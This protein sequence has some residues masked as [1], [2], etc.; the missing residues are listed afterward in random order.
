MCSFFSNDIPIVVVSFV[1][2]LLI[3]FKIYATN[4]NILF[5]ATFINMLPAFL[6]GKKMI[7][8]TQTNNNH[9]NAR[10]YLWY[11][12]KTI[13]QCV[14][15][16]TIFSWKKWT[17]NWIGFLPI[18]V[19]LDNMKIYNIK[20]KWNLWSEKEA[21]C[22]RSFSIF[23]CMYWNIPIFFYCLYTDKQKEW[24][25]WDTHFFFSFSVEQNIGSIIENGYNNEQQNFR[26]Y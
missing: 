16:K 15:Y 12:G 1:C 26:F 17:L 3:S 10:T 14:S 6:F 20:I 24:N 11:L 18:A 19:I 4:F 7:K 13:F 2:A 8:T 25:G 5:C 9:K 23:L 21:H 22:I